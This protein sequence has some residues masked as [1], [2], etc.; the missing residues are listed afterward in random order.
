MSLV[1]NVGTIGGLV[2]LEGR[3]RAGDEGRG[4]AGLDGVGGGRGEIDEVFGGAALDPEVLRAGGGVD[5]GDEA[6][7]GDVVGHVAHLAVDTGGRAT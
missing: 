7:V 1:R 6:E 4:L 3:G 2:H 5:V